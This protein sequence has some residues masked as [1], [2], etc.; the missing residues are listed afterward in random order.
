[1]RCQWGQLERA[2][3]TRV[4]SKW[5]FQFFCKTRLSLLVGCDYRDYCNFFRQSDNRDYRN[6]RDYHLYQIDHDNPW[7]FDEMRF[8]KHFAK[9]EGRF[10]CL[11]VF[12]RGQRAVEGT[13]GRR[14]DRGS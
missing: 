4:D 9:Q 12:Q 8:A 6:S 7:G 14:G 1:V 2:D 10:A 5:P 11:A 13:V 3:T